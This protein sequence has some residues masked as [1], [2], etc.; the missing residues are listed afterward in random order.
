MTDNI[1]H[2]KVPSK[3]IAGLVS[4]AAYSG[5][6]ILNPFN[7]KNMDLKYMELS[8]DGQPVPNRPF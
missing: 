4:L 6:Y 8:V 1:F 7:F 2:G 3:I 5:E